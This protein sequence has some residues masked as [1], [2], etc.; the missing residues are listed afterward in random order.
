MDLSV[1][2]VNYNVRDFL[3]QSIESIKKSIHSIKAEIIVVDNASD[4]G[5]VEMIRSNFKSVIIIQNQKNIGFGKANNKA[6]KIAKG[7][8]VLLINPD[9][10]VQ[11]DTIPK[12][13]KYLKENKNV[14]LV[15]CKI[16]NSDGTL[17]LACRRSIPTPWNAFSKIIGLSKIFPK[18]KVF[19]KY[20]L[21]YLD[22]NKISEVEALSG[23]FMMFPKS[24]YK[25]IGGFDEQFFMYGEDLDFCFRVKKSG[26]KIIYNP[27]TQIIHYKGESAKRSSIDELNYFYESMKLF[28]RKHFTFSLL[29]NFVIETSISIN[30]LIA[31]L[32][33]LFR[34]I[35]APTL[36]LFF[37][38]VALLLA[39]F[40]RTNNI[41]TYPTYALPWVYLG[42]IFIFISS[43]Y[44]IKVYSLSR[45]SISRTIIGVSIAFLILATTTAFVK[46][47][48]FSRAILIYF[49]FFTL[50]FLCGWRLLFWL[51]GYSKHF[52]GQTLFSR[53]GIIVGVSNSSIKI[54]SKL[55]LNIIDGYDIIGF[56]DTSNLRVGEKINGVPILGS[57]ESVLKIIIDYKITDIIF[58]SS[59]LK[60]ETI[61]SII[62]KTKKN[63]L[64]YSVVPSSVEMI[65]SK[66]G[67]SYFGEIPFIALNYSSNRI[68]YK[69]SKKLFDLLIGITLLIIIGP[70]VYLFL[71]IKN[72]KLIFRSAFGLLRGNIST[73]GRS[74]D[75]KTKK[76]SENKIGLT[77]ITQLMN[78][79]NFTKKEKE[80]LELYYT[81]NQSLRF[82]IE[83]FFKALIQRKINFIKEFTW[84][85]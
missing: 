59:D 7:K 52:K 80:E 28:Y 30:Y 13:I 45:L 8:Y 56:V 40:Y 75:F 50:L 64:N 83:I 33:N 70:F 25:I 43:L 76:I 41:F 71:N 46:E 81:S 3:R 10:I 58:S 39:E 16:L 14:G 24:V 51:K 23:S 78:T 54:L 61:L 42:P 85:K 9:T 49:Y 2:I 69:I 18:T 48:A 29:F 44:F 62:S 74:F 79:E 22:E 20:N 17:Q 68:I 63:Y 27:G 21:T 72:K 47:F 1:L 65:I 84:Q 53:R 32:K 38:S 55:R 36:D 19:S 35:F 12:L 37:I 11:E 82:D 34:N 15:G 26:F 77:G 6:L 57:T 67:I 60:N 31:T 4:D 73:V 5:S 66:S